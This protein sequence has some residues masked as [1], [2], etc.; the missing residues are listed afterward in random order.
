[1]SKKIPQYTY[2]PLETPASVRVLDLHPAPAFSD[3][4]EASLVHVDR[5]QRFLPVSNEA[6]SVRSYDAVSYCW[7]N[8][9]SSCVLLLEGHAHCITPNVDAMLRQLRRD[10]PKTRPRRLWIDAICLNQ[11][12]AEE[13]AT[14]V[15][16]MGDIFRQADKVRIWLGTASDA[17]SIPR[18]FAFWKGLAAT[19]DHTSTSSEQKGLYLSALW[20][21]ISGDADFQPILDFLARPW[22]RRRWILQ[23]VSLG[24]HIKV[25][26]GAHSIPWAWLQEGICEMPLQY[27]GFEKKH[28]EAV[29]SVRGLRQGRAEYLETLRLFHTTECSEPR[30]RLFALYGMAS[31]I[32]SPDEISDDAFRLHAGFISYK[33][34]YAGTWVEAYKSFAQA[35]IT[36]GKIDGI[37]DHLASFG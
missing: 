5:N 36:A 29:Q 4:L 26:C 19:I 20:S 33:V 7:G 30:D 23:E 1:M 10:S 6:S 12:D 25:H 11:H 32:D 37:F 31:D 8:F 21:S 34:T 2:R 3:P 13:K 35:C 14:Q 9:D 24:H 28:A 17:D 22:F 16:L 18:I 15:Q 27:P